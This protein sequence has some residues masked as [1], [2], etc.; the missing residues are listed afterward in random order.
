[1]MTHGHELDKVVEILFSGRATT[2]MPFLSTSVTQSQ[3]G[4]PTSQDKTKTQVIPQLRRA[5]GLGTSGGRRLNTA[6]TFSITAAAG[7]MLSLVNVMFLSSC[8]PLS[9][10]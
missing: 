1:M 6:F 8:C 7:L 4:S 9:S 5:V 3:Q 10:R 2:R